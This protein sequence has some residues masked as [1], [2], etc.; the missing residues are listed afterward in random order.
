MSQLTTGAGLPLRAYLPPLARQS[1][2]SHPV[3]AIVERALPLWRVGPVVQAVEER[4]QIEIL[5]RIL[6]GRRDL[7]AVFAVTPCPRGVRCGVLD[8]ARVEVVSDEL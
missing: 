3:S 6:F 5:L 1:C 2:T 4:D 8:R 7:E